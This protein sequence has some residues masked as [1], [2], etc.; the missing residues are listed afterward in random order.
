MKKVVMI[1]TILVA[2]GITQQVSA[3]NL[4]KPQTVGDF[5]KVPEKEIL[6]SSKPWSIKLSTEIAPS[7]FNNNNVYV[8]DETGDKLTTFVQYK[9]GTK[10]GVVRAPSIGYEEN[11]QY[12]L[13]ITDG[14]ESTKGVPLARGVKMNFELSGENDSSDKGIH[15]YTKA[16]LESWIDEEADLERLGEYPTKNKFELTVEE[17][18]DLLIHPNEYVDNTE[19]AME[20]LS[21]SNGYM[22]VYFNRDY[23]SIGDDWINDVRRYYVDP[24][25]YKGDRYSTEQLPNLFDRFV[26]ETRDEKRISESVFISDKS[27]VFSREVPRESGYGSDY[28]VITRGTQYIRYASGTNLPEGVELNKW[29]KRD[30]DLQT[31]TSYVHPDDRQWEAVKNLYEEIHPITSY[32]EVTK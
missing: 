30:I 11:V 17:L 25:T 18:N 2:F 6:N 23:R 28:Q 31:A 15:E 21:D 20:I 13:V 14:V 10:E 27:T 7:T 9:E 29:Y 26:Q 8:T 3:E 1:M 5:V 4:E 24:F 19:R 12:T 32:E 22:D 16:E